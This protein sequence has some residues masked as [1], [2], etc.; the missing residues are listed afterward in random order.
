MNVQSKDVILYIDEPIDM[1]I[2]RN[3]KLVE[4]IENIGIKVVNDINE[5]KGLIK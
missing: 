5:L 4:K 1:T 3:V 2:L